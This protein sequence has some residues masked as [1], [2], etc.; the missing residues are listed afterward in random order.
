MKVSCLAGRNAESKANRKESGNERDGESFERL[1]RWDG[2]SGLRGN[3][4]F[5]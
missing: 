4:K 2:K 5:G 1:N 3:R